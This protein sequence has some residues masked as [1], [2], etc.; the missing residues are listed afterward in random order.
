MVK[1]FGGSCKGQC[2]FA[3]KKSLYWIG[4]KY[5]ILFLFGQKSKTYARFLRGKHFKTFGGGSKWAEPLCLRK[6]CIWLA[7]NTQFVPFWSKINNKITS[8][9]TLFFPLCH[10]FSNVISVPPNLL[11][12]VLFVYTHSQIKSFERWN[13]MQS[14]LNWHRI[15]FWMTRKIELL[16]LIIKSDQNAQIH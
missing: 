12:Q 1:H 15:A 6:L 11:R 2:P 9:V 14:T 7:Q 16:C 13:T 10:F 3:R 4:P 8:K 5:T